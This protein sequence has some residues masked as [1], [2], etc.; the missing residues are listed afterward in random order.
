MYVKKKIKLESNIYKVILQITL[1][2][3]I[4]AIHFYFCIPTYILLLNFLIVFWNRLLIFREKE[5]TFSL[6]FN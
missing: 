6:I 2:N 5:K 4:F 3:I 1:I